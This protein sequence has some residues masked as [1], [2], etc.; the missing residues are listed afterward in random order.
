MGRDLRV[1][2]VSK[3]PITE[4]EDIA[5]NET[6]SRMLLEEESLKV[7]YNEYRNANGL[8]LIDFYDP[9]QANHR[10]SLSLECLVACFKAR[11]LEPGEEEPG[12]FTPGSVLNGIGLTRFG[13]FDRKQGDEM[14]IPV[15]KRFDT[16]QH[17][18][19]KGFE[20]LAVPSNRATLLVD[21]QDRTNL[22]KVEE[23]KRRVNRL[24]QTMQAPLSSLEMPAGSRIP[25][26]FK[27][28][29]VRAAS[30]YYR[31]LCVL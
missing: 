17:C 29:Y 7:A 9:Q 3:R 25:K 31:A 24:S 18:L 22:Q 1:C 10:V 30:R 28:T 12:A 21:F 14:G 6:I 15:R 27:K 4:P 19:S 20:A 26:P 23:N 11:V 16:T 8:P 2:E 5:L 13:R